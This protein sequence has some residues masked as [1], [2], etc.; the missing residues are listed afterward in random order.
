MYRIE[1]ILEDLYRNSHETC[2]S[3]GYYYRK[4]YVNEYYRTLG[5]AHNI[6]TVSSDILHVKKNAHIKYKKLKPRKEEMEIKEEKEKRQ[7]EEE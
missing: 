5:G 6:N 3:I 7:I 1:E 2:K 4:T